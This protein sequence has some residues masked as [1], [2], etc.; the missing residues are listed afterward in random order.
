VAEQIDDVTVSGEDAKADGRSGS[1]TSRDD[2]D[3]GRDGI[4]LAGA[5]WG[6]TA[7][8]RGFL[9]WGS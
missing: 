4:P 6:G 8:R 9:A 1:T 7:G 2:D 3:D 5:C